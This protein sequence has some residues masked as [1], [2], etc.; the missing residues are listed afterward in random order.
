MKPIVSEVKA[1]YEDR[2]E[3]RI[4]DVDQ[5][6]TEQESKKFKLTAIPTFIFFDKSGKQV[7]QVVGTLTKAEF[8]T[9]IEKLL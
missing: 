5:P 6:E 2:V 1:E 8:R 9:K 3:F 4:I 7:D